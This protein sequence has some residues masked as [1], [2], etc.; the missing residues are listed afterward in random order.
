MCAR[1][2]RKLRFWTL[3]A[4][5]LISTARAEDP[6]TIAPH[7]VGNYIVVGRYP[8]SEKTYQGQVTLTQDGSGLKMA[9]TIDGKVVEGTATLA[10]ATADKLPVLR[11]RFEAEGKKFE[12]VYQWKTDLDNYFRF[13]GYIYLPGADHKVPGLEVWFP[14]EP[15][16]A[17]E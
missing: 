9:R 2:G 1:S 8:D 15:F 5:C 14:A 7:M 13:T 12:G 6:A 16:K 3:L 10:E 17:E 11:I 4:A